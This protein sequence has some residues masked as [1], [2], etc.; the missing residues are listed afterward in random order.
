MKRFRFFSMAAIVFAVVLGNVLFFQTAKAAWTSQNISSDVSNPYAIA[1]QGTYVYVADYDI[2][3]VIRMEAGGANRVNLGLPFSVNKA[4]GIAVDDS[5]IYISNEEF[6]VVSIMDLDGSNSGVFETGAWLDRP[7]GLDVDNSYL[8]VASTG[9]NQIVRISK[10]GSNDTTLIDSDEINSPYDVAIHGSYIYVTDSG[11]NRIIRTDMN[12][13][14]LEVLAS[15]LNN[16]RGIDV[17]GSGNIYF[18]DSGINAV[19]RIDAVNL[20]VE[21]L[22][23]VSSPAGVAVG[24]DGSIYITSNQMG[25]TYVTKLQYQ[26]DD[27]V[28]PTVSSVTVPANTT[29]KAGDTLSFT[30]NFSE[31]VNVNTYGGTPR[32]VLTLGTEEVYASYVGGTGT[33]VLTFSYTIPSGALDSDG[34]IVGA[35]T[36]NGATLKDA[37]GNDANLTLN[38]VGSTSGILVD[39]VEPSTGAVTW[40]SDK[41]YIQGEKL[42][43]RIFFSEAVFVDTAGGIPYIG[44]MLNSGGTVRAEYVSKDTNSLTFEY[45]IAS[46]DND[47]NGIGVSIFINANG[48]TIKDAAGNDAI[49]LLSSKNTENVKVDGVAPAVSSVSVPS[50]GIYKAGQ[51]LDFTV[52]YNENVLVTGTPYIPVTLATGGTVQASYISGSGTTALT[53]RY[54]VVSGNDDMDGITL[55]STIIAGGGSLKDSAGNNAS[56]TLNSVGAT[57]GVLIDAAIPVVTSVTV[58][59]SGSYK[60]GDTLDFTVNFSE[61]VI[62]TGTDSTLDIVVGSTTRSAVYHANTATSITYSY[63]I[64]EGDNDSDGITVDKIILNTS[65]VKDAAANNAVMI[66]N[67]V[68]D[69]SGVLIDITAPTVTSVTVPASGSYKVG[70]TLDFTVNFSEAVT[71]T[72][73]DSVLGI[74]VGGASRNAAYQSKTANS[75]TYRYTIQVGD[76]DSDGITVGSITLNATT[77]KD[78]AANNAVMILNSVGDTSGVL[79]DITAPTV[80]SVTV[81]ASGSYKV[82]DTLDFTVNFSEAVTVTGTDTVLGIIMGGNSRRAAYLSKTTTSITYRYTVQAGDTDSDG[83]T[84][85]LI[86]LNTTTIRDTAAN[87]AILL[88]NS[89]GDTSGVLIDI[90]SPV[91]T[92]VTVPSSGSY[93]AGDTLDFT[94]NFSET[95]IVSGTNS[96]LGLT[97]GNTS[98]SAAYQSKTTTSITY[99]YTIQAGDSDSDGI[100]VGSITLNTTTVQDASANNAVLTLNSVG[101]TS[102]V[103]IDAIIPVV[104]SVT[105]PSSGINKVGDTLDFIVNFNKAVT[106]TGTD[107]TLGIVVGSTTR[108]AA[109]HSNTATSITYSYTVQEGDN[110]SDGIAVDTITLNTTTV[111]D[112]ATNN[113]VLTLNSVGDTSGVLIDTTAPAVISVTVPPFDSYTVGDT[114]DFTVNFSE[115]V[116]VTGVDSVLGITIGGTLRNAVYQSKTADSITYRYTVQAGDTDSDGIT[117]GSITLNATTVED[118]ATNNAVMTLHSVGVTTGVL[119]DTTEPAPV[120]NPSAGG[121][122]NNTGNS[123][124]T[125][126]TL[127]KEQQR[128]DGAPAASI[129]NNIDSLK[130]GVLTVAEQAKVASGED[131]KVTL[132]IEDIN[133]TVSDADKKLVEE[134]LSEIQQNA[135]QHNTEAT[136]LYVDISLFKQVGNG[137][138][139][140]VTQTSNKISISIE[141]PQELWNDNGAYSRTYRIVRI[142]DNEVEILDGIYD[143]VTHLFTFETDRFSVYA[144]TYQDTKNSTAGSTVFK[145]FW[146]LRLTAKATATTQKLSYAKVSGADGY[147]IYGAKCG[148]DMTELADVEG[149]VTS[150]TVNNLKQATYYKYQVKAYKLINGKKVIIAVSKTVHSVTTSKIYG[151]P[152]KVTANVSSVTLEAGK[153]K[154]LVC[155]VELPEGRKLQKHVSVIRYES[156][157]NAIATVS[158][159]G[160]ITTKS[161]GVCYVYA[162][163]QNGVYKKIKITVK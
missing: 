148:K 128:E 143:P 104:T 57:S 133:K 72:G 161:K 123:S 3:N 35:L 78:A 93:K 71:V 33:A 120:P 66:L 130:A 12:G 31:A 68:G 38:S 8:Y 137:E 124:K 70:D 114:L 65:T 129:N 4:S 23:T 87:D 41:I 150:Y 43:F 54:T 134:K 107:S 103:L 50:N 132:K 58:P 18:A 89:I 115:A 139:T 111:Q 142:H 157:N 106:V 28:A 110:D 151:N 67:S 55:G 136:V 145:D 102:G 51:N 141:I 163:A 47:S 135:E 152:V 48:G 122:N 32:I 85:G 19:K 60:A 73:T 158:S 101:A 131:A 149:T 156:T 112:A 81:P 121:N 153:T 42:T 92:S 125:E 21:T 100:T 20:S 80:T 61:D 75:I 105:V 88:L 91:V 76:T 13:N 116:T 147:L 6:G 15:G 7:H 155:K 113:A 154:L 86:E 109:Y 140:K 56:M 14:G 84:V 117:V 30:V 159:S 1:A 94:V 10:D 146:H 138:V 40:P 25:S 17:D 46:G 9:A 90:T 144:L 96:V 119:I 34:I 82:G 59:F 26:V 53:F 2:D 11:N 22:Y 95:V 160:K 69:T 37:A 52:N 99:C 49:L 39:A 127:E 98:R 79:I 126:G 45:T 74:T 29:Y 36:A 27:F 24:G 64:Q 97:V 108:N 16:P 118:T 162:Y 62:I 5:T 83:I 44:L 63:T 77:V